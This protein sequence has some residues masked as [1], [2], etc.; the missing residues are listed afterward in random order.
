MATSATSRVPGD[1]PPDVDEALVDLLA[2]AVV[3]NMKRCPPVMAN[4]P[5][6]FGSKTEFRNQI[7][8]F[9]EES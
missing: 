2:H 3:A 9:E 6:G 4:S 8:P 5:G 7:M 1:L